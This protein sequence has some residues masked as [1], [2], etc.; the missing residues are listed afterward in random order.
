MSLPEICSFL[1]SNGF[2]FPPL[3]IGIQTDGRA[4]VACLLRQGQLGDE[5]ILPSEVIACG[6]LLDMC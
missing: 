3:R 2:K 1:K 4:R 6:Q 5:H